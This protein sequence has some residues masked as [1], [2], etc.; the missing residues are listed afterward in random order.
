M[1]RHE[2]ISDV[3]SCVMYSENNI[4]IVH[5][6]IKYISFGEYAF[7]VQINGTV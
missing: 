6:M 1:T 4:Y 3:I 2:N 5:L 7:A